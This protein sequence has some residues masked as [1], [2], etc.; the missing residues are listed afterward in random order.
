[1]HRSGGGRPIFELASRSPPPSD[2]NR[3]PMYTAGMPRI[4]HF[5]GIDVHMYFD[6]HNPPHIHAVYGGQQAAVDIQ[7]GEVLAGSLPRRARRLLED[8]ID[9]RR[10]ELIDRWQQATSG[11]PIQPIAPL[12]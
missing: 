5:Y 6:D 4:S 12:D 3:Y 7:T 11:E 1:M 8:W 9:I 2:R 10:A